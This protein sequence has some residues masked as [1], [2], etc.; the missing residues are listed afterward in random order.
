METKNLTYKYQTDFES[1]GIACPPSDYRGSTMTVYRWVFDSI[2]HA[3]NFTSQYHKNPKR[4]LTKS[5]SEKCSA[6]ALSMFKN[7]TA[8]EQ[9]FAALKDS[10]G[11]NVYKSLGTHVAVGEITEDDGVNGRIDTNG[12]FNHH[13]C[14]SCKYEERFR[15]VAS[16]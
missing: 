9:R 10:I 14:L 4:F 11:E 12:H 3:D 1:L 13:C 7:L 8:A 15:I 5:D 2:Q 6:M 16:L